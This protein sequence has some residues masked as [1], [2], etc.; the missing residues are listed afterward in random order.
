MVGAIDMQAPE[1]FTQPLGDPSNRNSWICHKKR[2]KNKVVTCP[3]PEINRSLQ[4][5]TAIYLMD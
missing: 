4:A 3:W 5:C 1:A 2:L